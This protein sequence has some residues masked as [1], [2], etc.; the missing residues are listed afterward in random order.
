MWSGV[1][2]DVFV[3]R[4]RPIA[5][6]MHEG[7][8]STRQYGPGGEIVHEDRMQYTPIS[9]QPNVARMVDLS[10]KLSVGATAVHANMDWSAKLSMRAAC[11]KRQLARSTMLRG[12]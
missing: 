1:N 11:S 7:H 5:C 2:N 3:N 9:T 6:Q 8:R 10:A 4:M 12:W